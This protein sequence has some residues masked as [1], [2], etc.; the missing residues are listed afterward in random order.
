[1][2]IRRLCHDID[3]VV[4]EAEVLNCLRIQFERKAANYFPSTREYAAIF[5]PSACLS[6]E[7]DGLVQHASTYACNG[8]VSTGYNNS[9][10][11]DD[12]NKQKPSGFFGS[13]SPVC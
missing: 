4:A 9:N 1:M 7:D 13:V 11:C 8:S 6:G 12:N 3:K 2:S 5:G 10:V